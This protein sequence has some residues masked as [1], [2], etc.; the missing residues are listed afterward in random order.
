MDD[1][2]DQYKAR[3]VAKGWSVNTQKINTQK[4]GINYE[5]TFS[6]VV[7]FD[8]IRVILSVVTSDNLKLMQFDVKTAFLYGNLQE[9]VYMEQPESCLQ[10]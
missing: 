5:E 7:R 9:D 3:L 2:P 4:S 8:T 6:S 1:S 10:C